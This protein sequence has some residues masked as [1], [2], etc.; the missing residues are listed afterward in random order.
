M[1]NHPKTK[2]LPFHTLISRTTQKNRTGVLSP[3]VIKSLPNDLL[4]EVL[5]K[6][7]ASSYVDLVQAKL[8]TKQFLEASKDRYIFQ[9]VS[10]GNFENHLWNNSP[11]FWSFIETC[12]NNENPESLY[13]KGMLEFFTHCKEASGLAYLKLSA[14]KGYVDACYV[15]SVILYAS[16]AKDEGFEFLKNHEAK[17]RNKMAECRWRVKRFVSYLWIKNRISSS[18]ED[19]NDRKC[20]KNIN[21][22]VNERRNSWDW[23][24]EDDYYGEYTC[25]KCKWNN[26]VFRFCKMLRTGRYS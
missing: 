12:N 2:S 26:E 19:P 16:K 1:A 5:A 9:H 25:E 6:V 20:D 8:A 10:L 3:T 13:R 14:Q 11:E 17:L 18:G 24:D 4:T 15:C 23:K 21:C 7:A 22:R